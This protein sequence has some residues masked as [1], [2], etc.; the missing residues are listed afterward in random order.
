MNKTSFTA[1]LEKEGDLYV[2]LCTD[3]DVASQGATVEEA[4]ANL[5][6]AVELF[7]ECADPAEIAARRHGERSVRHPLR[8]SL[9]ISGGHFPVGRSAICR[10][11]GFMRHFTI[12]Y[13]PYL[14]QASEPPALWAQAL[15][16]VHLFRPLRQ[17]ARRRL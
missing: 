10:I 11:C 9:W 13:R 3:L 7:L 8:S 17:E 2:S 15:P 1:I 4:T 6:E 12:S 14:P 16:T 5:K